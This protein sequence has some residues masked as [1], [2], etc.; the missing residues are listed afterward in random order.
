MEKYKVPY[1]KLRLWI[2]EK[3][4]KFSSTKDLAC[5]QDIVGQQRAVEALKLGLEIKASGYNI[6][7]T[8]PVGTGRTTTVK[9]LLETL[10]KSMETPN[11]KCYV[12]NFKNP[13]QPRLITLPAGMGRVFKNS[14][15]ELIEYLKRNIP[16]VL[17]S[18]PYQKKRQL[19]IDEFKEKSNRMVLEFEK[20]VSK[21]GFALQ[22]PAPM[23]KPEIVYL[24]E[25]NPVKIS[26]LLFAV[27]E[28]KMSRQE[29]ETIKEKAQALTDELNTLFKEIRNLEKETREKL[30]NLD[31]ETVKP[32]L[33]ER[34]NEIKEKLK[35]E[36]VNEYL[37]EV[38][39]AILDDIT[40]FKKEKK[41]EEA[42]FP[43]IRDI[44]SVDPYLEFRVNLLVDNAEEVGAPIIFENT[45]TFK[46]LFGT[47]EKVWD[48]RGQWRT[49]FT[50]I[51]AGSLV[52]ADGGFLV[53]NALDV[54]LEGTW[55]ALKRC[56]RIR[57]VDITAY[58]PYSLF[59]VTALKPEPID[60][61]VKVIMIGDAF[62]YTLLATYD[63]DFKKIF[64]VRADFDWTMNL[65]EETIR[66]YAN[67]VRTIVEKENLK[68]FSASAIAK[69]VEYG[70]RLGGRKNKLSTRFGII[71]DIL[72][73]AS[74]WAEKDNSEL[75][76]AK[77]ITKAIEMRDYRVKLIE[78]K[79][80]E[81]IDEGLLLIDTEGKVVGQIN[82]LSIYDTG[83]YFFGRPTRITAKVAVGTKGI[84]NIEREAQL[85][86][87]IHDKGVLILSGYLMSKYAQ[88]FPIV[89]NASICFEQSYGG[90]EGDSASSAEL[91]ALISA[92]GNIPLRQDIAVTGS[93]NQKGEIQAIGGVNEKIEGFFEVC[94]K[95]GLTG[96]QGVIIP[97][98]NVD[99]L[100]LKEEVCEAVKKGLFHI[101]AIRNVDEGLEILTE[102]KAE[103]VHKI[104]KA[105][106][107]ELAENYKK[108]T[109]KEEKE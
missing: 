52:K 49:D 38:E 9:Y 33:E 66:E 63:E 24:V 43:F 51:K 67:V 30:A 15:D 109:A 88:E 25:N 27:E 4:L 42:P 106:L 87:K 70:I 101:Y 14:M 71:T 89:M 7:V 39:Q 76:L 48:A 56:L 64:K 8:G 17:E 65:E 78:E 74:Y 82:G 16:L 68:H 1:E 80:Q 92:I 107:K 46:N 22:Q 58:D 23:V 75:V 12:N 72:K 41:E 3:D 85:S 32:I 40:I 35:N 100:M 29:Y 47:I 31:R 45:P 44:V 57:K 18:D 99:D 73:E 50:K 54:L 95:R 59:G 105:R 61:N 21:E 90:V 98:S 79:I 19:I 104:V 83:E 55:Y 6:F 97:E 108:F 36:K 60:I 62:L 20:K 96:T 53:L 84:I 2:N 11:D 5:S 13:D 93:V 37:K 77:H 28:G 86:G 91:F 69:L 34:L 102:M 94:K 26:D 103:E 81:M 10:E